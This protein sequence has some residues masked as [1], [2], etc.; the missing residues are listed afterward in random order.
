M[1]ALVL[2]F[3]LVP[4]GAL[5]AIQGDDY[6]G[7]ETV[8]ARDLTV[9][10]APV[11]E[12]TYGILCDADG[13]VLWS[14]GADEQSAMASITKMMTAILVLEN[15]SLKDEYTV[16]YNAA[17]IGESS[18]GLYVGASVS[19][20]DLL[21]CL[22]VH[23]GNDAAI[24]LAEGLAGSETAFVKMMNKKAKALGLTNTHF[25]NP[26]GLDAD[27]H[28]S[29]ASDLCLLARYCMQNETF[30]KIAGTTKKTVDIDGVTAT[31]RS[32]NSLLNTWDSC[33]GI[34]TGY[35]N[36]AGYC[37]ASAAVEAGVELY[38]VVL[39]C[40]DEAERFT[41]SYRLLS[42]GFSHYREVAL[43]T[44]GEE[45]AQVALES[46]LDVTVA[47]GLAEDV[48]AFVLDYDGDITVDVS[49]I[50]QTD[51]VS[52]G[53][54]VGTIT[55]RQGQKEIAS[56][57]LVAFESKAAPNALQSIWIALCRLVGF[58]SGAVTVAE[59]STSAT[60][61]DVIRSDD[62]TGEEISDELSDAIE[63]DVQS[64]Y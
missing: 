15:A 31:Y 4:G 24:C 40:T 57:A 2:A 51:G 58:F 34:K 29:T 41:D 62:L 56:A 6:I 20:K 55:W 54:R 28:Y 39:G 45:L 53:D 46:Y 47:A 32:T 59:S 10:E 48:S 49:L 30:R 27:G 7:L 19:V 9:T 8:A 64:Q 36:K 13:N 5:A 42:W 18:A 50:T 11:V 61:I 37:L 14:R 43:G 52:E 3:A 26:H 25:A 23:S 60:G 17:T 35:T 63:A 16:S 44:A 33:I 1:L 21:Y 22:M 12:C 38:A